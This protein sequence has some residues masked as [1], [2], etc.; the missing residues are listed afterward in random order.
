MRIMWI[1]GEREATGTKGKHGGPS[2][3]QSV[4]KVLVPRKQA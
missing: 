3:K 4:V 1:R 2:V